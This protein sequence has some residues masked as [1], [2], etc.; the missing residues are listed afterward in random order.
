MNAN[1]IYNFLDAHKAFFA[2]AFAWLVKDWKNIGGLTGLKAFIITGKTPDQ[3]TITA[4]IK[5]TTEI[6]PS[7]PAQPEIKT[8]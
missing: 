3:N 1:D 7:S 8:T 2:L 4:E 6:K 5:T